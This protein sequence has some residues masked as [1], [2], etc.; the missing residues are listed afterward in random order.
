MQRRAIAILAAAGLALLLATAPAQAKLGLKKLASFDNPTYVTGPPGASGPLFVTERKGLVRV[1]DHGRKLKRPFLDIRDRVGLRSEGGLLSIAFAPDYRRSRKFYVDY[2]DNGQ[3]IRI[4]EFRAKR[5]SPLKA[6]PSSRQEVIKI[7]SP[8][9]THKG[10]QLQ[11]T[12]GGWLLASTGDGGDYNSPSKKPQKKNSL[13]GKI[14]RIKPETQQPRKQR[15]WRPHPGNPFAGKGKGSPAILALGLRN[16]WRF[17]LDRKH[18][19]RIVIGDVGHSHTEEVDAGPL[20]KVAGAN[21]GWPCFEGDKRFLGCKVK[22]HRRP[23]FT[24]AHKH[25]RCSITGGYVNRDKG[26]PRG[27]RYFYGDF[28]TGE[29]RTL[30]LRRGHSQGTG[31]EVPALSSFGEDGRG[32]LYTVSLSGPVSRIVSR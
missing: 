20:D 6:K 11:M 19:S 16:P 23:V 28:C 22:H 4:D 7:P 14:L 15:Q 3:D 29:I 25:D 21:F 17:S 31:L 10:G 9:D 5:S 24:Y 8:A 18:P 1:I 12:P 30:D 26:L 13:L 32:N 27:G 2:V